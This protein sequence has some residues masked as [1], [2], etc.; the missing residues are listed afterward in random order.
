MPISSGILVTAIQQ[1]LRDFLHAGCILFWNFLTIDTENRKLRGTSRS[2]ITG[3]RFS[4]VIATNSLKLK[5]RNLDLLPSHKI[6]TSCLK[7][8]R[9]F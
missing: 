1:K 9:L 6:P 7:I 4:E 8:G 2:T 3:L 5:V